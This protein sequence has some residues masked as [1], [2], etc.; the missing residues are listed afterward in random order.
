[1]KTC[2]HCNLSKDL[3]CFAKHTKSKDGLQSY[4]KD[5]HH[6]INALYRLNNKE[7]DKERNKLYH[8]QKADIVRDRHY[9]NRYAISYDYFLELVENQ[10]KKCK[11]C[12]IDLTLGDRKKTCAVLDHCH[13]TGKIRG[14]LCTMCNTA[15]G[16]FCDSISILESAINYLEE[17]K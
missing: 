9:K 6:N 16:K 8:K 13:V 14:V 2:K 5:C 1:M 11:I 7:K 3:S 17:S 15:L 4:C 10:N 12:K